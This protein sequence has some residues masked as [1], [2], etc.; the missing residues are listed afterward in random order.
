MISNLQANP[1]FKGETYGLNQASEKVKP[2]SIIKV[3]VPKNSFYMGAEGERLY[4]VDA[5][6]DGKLYGELLKEINKE[7]DLPSS[8][9]D[10]TFEIVG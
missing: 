6:V 9:G 4:K 1:R 5:V 2:G 3:N 10:P 8:Q 7:V